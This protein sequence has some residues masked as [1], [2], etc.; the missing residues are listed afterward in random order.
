MEISFKHTKTF[1]YVL[2][3]HQEDVDTILYVLHGYGHL[4]RY[5][6][7]KFQSVSKNILVVA[8]EGMHRFYLNGSSGR[9][10]ASW[11][12]KEAREHDIEDNISYLNEVD[13]IISKQF[14]SISKKILLGFSQ[15]GAT[16][17]RWFEKGN[18]SFDGLIIWGSDLA[19]DTNLSTKNIPQSYFVLGNNDP[20][21]KN[22]GS[23]KVIE[24]YISLGFNF[25]PFKG[26]HDIE[27][28]T[29]NKILNKIILA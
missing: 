27:Q 2:W 24:E 11:M 23:K 28:K 4:V 8:P 29:L 6:I 12:T 13:R 16:A 14:P 19:Y 18:P 3:N 26:E 25:I 9:V 7:R 15:G 21:F 22:E 5:F 17:L 1:R 10:G 20:Y